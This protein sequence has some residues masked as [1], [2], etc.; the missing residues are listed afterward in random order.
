MTAGLDTTLEGEHLMFLVERY[1][2]AEAAETLPAAIAR[3]ARLCLLSEAQQVG[4]GLRVQY[5]YA[6]YLPSED[7]CFCLFRA[8]TADVVRALN[9]EAA[10]AFD[11][12]TA[13]V[14]VYP[15]VVS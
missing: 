4:N 12:I 11:R 5:V 7:T 8:A 10:F 9:D 14:Q 2:P 13:V 1:L 15:A 3:A 6:T